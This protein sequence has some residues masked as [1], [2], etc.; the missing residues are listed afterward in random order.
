MPL[1]KNFDKREILQAV[2]LDE[3]F[4]RYAA[5]CWRKR[6]EPY[7]PYNTGRLCSDVTI[8]PFSVQYNAPY[9]NEVYNN[10][11]MNF[12]KDKHPLATA[13]WNEVASPAVMDYFIQDLQE[14]IDRR[15]FDV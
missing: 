7:V 10:L 6:V 13:Q 15:K 4:G 8:K 2:Q 3:E 14:Y 9:A 11:K 1:L 5:E 12:R